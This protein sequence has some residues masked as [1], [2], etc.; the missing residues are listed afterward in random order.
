MKA[1]KEKKINLDKVHLSKLIRISDPFLMNDKVD[2]IIP[3]HSGRGS[4]YLNNDEWFYKSHFTDEPIMPGTL[5]IEA[6]LQTVVAI[7]YCDPNMK[8]KKY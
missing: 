3:G 5:Q 1:N 7:I 2:D 6:M 4:K 8:S